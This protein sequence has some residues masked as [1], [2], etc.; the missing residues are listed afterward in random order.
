MPDETDSLPGAPR[1]ERS[2]GSELLYA[3]GPDGVG[4]QRQ[5]A[6]GTSQLTQYPLLDGLGSVRN[7]V[8]QSGAI[9][10]STSYDATAR[11]ARAPER[12]SRRWA[13]PVSEPVPLMELSTFALAFTSRL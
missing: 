6:G 13:I 2:D 10:R 1:E 8:D 3:Y 5:A 9:V 4:A 7:L 12:S 11:C